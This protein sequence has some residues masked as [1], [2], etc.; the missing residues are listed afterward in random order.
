M[1]VKKATLVIQIGKRK[2]YSYD[3]LELLA[4]CG[5]SKSEA[6]RLLVQNAVKI[7]IEVEQKRGDD[8]MI[9]EEKTNGEEV[10]TDAPT[11]DAPAEGEA[12][13]EKK[14]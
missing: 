4:R 8:K 11:E 1:M 7:H 6:K 12:T 13:E 3:L 14:E 5:Y 10:T 9:D 2:V